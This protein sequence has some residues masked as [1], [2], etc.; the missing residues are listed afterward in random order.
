MRVP[1]NLPYDERRKML[2]EVG[3]LEKEAE[4]AN[5][6][7]RASERAWPEVAVAWTAAES[8]KDA[9]NAFL[10]TRVSFINMV[11]DL[12]GATGANI[13]HVAQGMGMDPRIGSRFM[14]AGLGYANYCLPKDLR[15]FSWV[16]RRILLS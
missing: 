13:E 14:E 15:A 7:G 5:A 8:I 2:E 1:Q 4:I 10:A 9:S 3:R 6:Y 11:A 12:S 16:A